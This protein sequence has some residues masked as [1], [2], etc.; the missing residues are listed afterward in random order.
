MENNKAIVATLGEIKRIEG[1][2][3]IVSASIMLNNVPI[4]QIV[5][6]VDTK[7]GTKVVYFDSNMCLS[8]NFI[9]DGNMDLTKYLAKSNVIFS[10]YGE[11]EGNKYVESF[12]EKNKQI[13][14][15]FVILSSADYCKRIGITEY[16][17]VK[18]QEDGK[19]NPVWVGTPK[20]GRVKTVRLKS[21]I[22]NGL[23]IELSKFKKYFNTEKEY[24]EIMKEGYT[25]THIGDIEIC[26]KYMPP[27]VRHGDGT[28]RMKGKKEPN[29]IIDGIFKFHFDTDQLLRNINKVN[30]EDII[31]ISRKVHGISGICANILVK[32]K[33]SL[34]EK[35]LKKI[36]IKIE[37]TEYDYIYASRGIVKNARKMKTDLLNKN[38]IWIHA[39][40][41][42]FEGKLHKS[43]TVYYEIIGYLPTGKM[44]QK[45]YDYGCKPGEYKIAVYRITMTN[46]DGNDIEYSWNMMKERCKQ[47]NV[48]MVEEF[49]YGK[50]RMFFMTG[51]YPIWK[52]KN[53]NITGAQIKEFEKIIKEAQNNPH[54]LLTKPEFEVL[55]A[56]EPTKQEIQE[57]KDN[58]IKSMN[59]GDIE[60]KNV[61]DII[62][63][64]LTDEDIR[65]RLY[66]MNWGK[67]FL[68]K[69]KETYLEKDCWD[70]ILPNKY[71][72]EGIVLRIEGLNI[73]SYKLKSEKFLLIESKAKDE[74]AE[75][76][77]E[78]EVAESNDNIIE[79]GIKK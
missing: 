58:L 41:K 56:F 13:Y 57:Y 21:V 52:I 38:D 50:A 67:Y 76:T 29:R 46:V 39:G 59:G 33:L 11:E 42:Y 31:S 53:D 48:D 40:K 63:P 6:G 9:D 66:N 36:G 72:D 79:V 32:K 68:G 5:T 25:F 77:E 64:T 14:Q 1:A 62:M 61:T 15:A 49:Y 26:H 2:D 71:P 7:E 24:N 3:R 37:D 4:T 47:L 17:M 8:D 28:N 45:G 12:K 78:N 54:L 70:S 10:C 73:R 74:G 16:D 65:K 44:V 34:I 27:V 55:D 18:G 69:L 30:M 23:V 22:S 19:V 35:I 51:A 60:N 20:F 75:D 43:E